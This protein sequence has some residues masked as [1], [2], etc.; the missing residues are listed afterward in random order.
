MEP[1]GA[2]QALTVAATRRVFLESSDT[3]PD[4]ALRCDRELVAPYCRLRRDDSVRVNESTVIVVCPAG[5]LGWFHTLELSDDG[6]QLV[7]G[8]REAQYVTD[9]APIDL[10]DPP[11]PIWEA[12]HEPGMDAPPPGPALPP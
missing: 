9:R 7:F 11:L 4:P 12:G 8:Q 5:A 2:T 1:F 10:E 6:A 3:E